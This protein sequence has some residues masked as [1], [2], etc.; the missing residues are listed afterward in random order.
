MKQIPTKTLSNIL[1]IFILLEYVHLLQIHYWLLGRFR[2]KAC[3]HIPFSFNSD[4]T[5]MTTRE[6]CFFQYFGH[7][8]RHLQNVMRVA[9][10]HTL[11][12]LSKHKCV[13]WYTQNFNTS[14]YV[15]GVIVI[16]LVCTAM[17]KRV[18]YSYLNYDHITLLCIKLNIRMHDTSH[19]SISF[20]HV[21]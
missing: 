19:L 11:D 15:L 9:Y 2:H 12:N 18:Y 4:H 7:L 14:C 17:S 10:I 20:K 21:L 1:L 8:Q 13:P 6:S 5:F 3:S 16:D